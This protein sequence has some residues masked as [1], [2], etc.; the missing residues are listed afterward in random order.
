MGAQIMVVEDNQHDR[1]LVAF[2]L[3]AFGHAAVISTNGL[4]AIERAHT[5]TP[6]L[7]LMD[8]LM[9][10]LDGYATL[11]RLREDVSDVFHDR[12]GVFH[13]AGTEERVPGLDP[14]GRSYAS[15]ASFSDLDGN[16]RLLQEIKTRLP[17]R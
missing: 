16:G 12:G 2:L 11:R 3:E 7:I 6:D 15:F 17:G 14:Q 5:A 13:P 1:S 8:I 10:G 4:E 9:P